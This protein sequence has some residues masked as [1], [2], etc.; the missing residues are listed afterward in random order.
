M[1]ET[2]R[3]AGLRTIIRASLVVGIIGTTVIV[4]RL[5]ERGAGGS[6]Q[7]PQPTTKPNAVNNQPPTQAASSIQHQETRSERSVSTA[8]T[9]EYTKSTPRATKKPVAGTP[10]TEARVEEDTASKD[11]DASSTFVA[12]DVMRVADAVTTAS[13]AGSEP[14]PVTI[15]GCLEM[16]PD[17]DEFRLADT[18]GDD[19]P[20]SRGWRTGFLTTRRV[21]V[22]LVEP[23]ESLGLRSN[24]GKRIAATGLLTSR[25]LKVS[26]LRVVDASCD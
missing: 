24:V 23:D 14:P 3:T 18:Q 26:A 25:N 21:P 8:P 17:G 2:H 11:T 9:A 19:A 7:Y 1:S 4:N 6:D 15:T 22:T 10:N 5:A 20:K 12:S 16:T 13:I